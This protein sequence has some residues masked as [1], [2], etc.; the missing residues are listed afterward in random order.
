MNGILPKSL[1]DS[2]LSK[3]MAYIIATIQGRA[4]Q[5]CLTRS[6]ITIGKLPPPIFLYNR[7][8]LQQPSSVQCKTVLLGVYYFR[9]ITTITCVP[10]HLKTSPRIE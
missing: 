6:G 1:T 5:R 4:E 8:L 2:L 3:M 7:E 9:K 10:L